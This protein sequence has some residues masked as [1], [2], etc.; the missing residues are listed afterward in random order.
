M[1]EEIKKVIVIDT[2]S[3]S[4][5]IKSLKK[6]IDLL[7]ESLEELEIGSAEYNE[8]L[9]KLSAKQKEYNSVQTKISN[10]TQTT[11]QKFESIAR[12]SSGLAAGYGAVTAAV[13][14]F[15]K[16]SEDLT[17]VMVRLQSAIALVQ[18]IGGL[19]DLLQELPRVGDAFKTL[20]TYINPFDAKLDDIATN[21]NKLDTDK[22]SATADE[23]NNINIASNGG[24]QGSGGSQGGKG[25]VNFSSPEYAANTNKSVSAVAA[26]A[27]TQNGLNSQLNYQKAIVGSL[28]AANT[29]YSSEITSIQAG[30][31]RQRAL[32]A[33]LTSQYKAGT[34]T[35][36]DYMMATL[37]SNRAIKV[38]EGVI[39][40]FSTAIQTNNTK[41]AQAKTAITGLNTAIANSGKAVSKAGQALKSAGMIALWTAIATIVGIV[42]NKVIDYVS[43]LNDAK[44]KEEEFQKSLRETTSQIAAGPIV[45]FQRL[46]TEYLKL[47]DSV[48][49]KEQFLKDY[50]EQLNETGLKL[51]TVNDLDNAFVNRTNDYINAIM[52]R[53]KAQAL[54]TKAIEI[55]EEYLT[56]RAAL[57]EQLTSTELTTKQAFKTTLFI[58]PWNLPSKQQTSAAQNSV[59]QSWAE[60]RAAVQAQIDAL[61]QKIQAKMMKMFSDIAGFEAEYY[62]YFT[63]SV[64]ETVGTTLEEKLNELD[65]WLKARAESKLTEEQR[66]ENE[67]NRLKELAK[68][69]NEALLEIEAWYQE[70][71]TKI[72][73]AARLKREADDK[74][75]SDER[76]NA[77]QAE[78]KRVRDLAVSS[79]LNPQDK[80]YETQYQQ[81]FAKTFGLSGQF[82][83]QSKDDLQRQY[84]DQVAYNNELFNLT[85]SRIEQEN[86]LLNQALQDASLTA[87]RKLEIERTL[88]ENQMALSDAA[89]EKEKKNISAYKNLQDAKNRALQSTLSVASNIAGSMAQIWGEESKTG[90]AFATAQALIDTYSSANAAYSAMAGIPI[91]GPGLG[92]AAAA[93]AIIAGIANVKAIWAVNESGTS[94]SPAVA[95]PPAITA[96]P[97]EYTRNLLGDKEIEELNQ[98][99]KCYVLESDITSTQNKVAVTESNAS[100]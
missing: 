10:S 45:Q 20:M 18:G 73:E 79:N 100:F 66:L 80:L 74:K 70:E 62:A 32:Q 8:T 85:K 63:E 59:E 87:D 94:S 67:Y 86:A 35:Q 38:G 41:I 12:I 53:A 3:S 60:N 26:M 93:A 2:K 29:K 72:R 23:L 92:I 31:D 15:G 37:K 16:E 98:P 47:G 84:D 91:V 11:I 76:W 61:D 55:Y 51:K 77:L 78:L 39:Q 68:D 81:G 27:S 82:T 48:K 19:K 99:V 25:S 43:A 42:I 24:P 57:E 97:V 34:I 9:S 65:Q 4:Q 64:N 50:A 96:P 1:A 21:L 30:I 44:K 52:A 28:T 13:S 7:T 6:D 95:A 90:K 36:Q 71:L 33:E 14:L 75:A 49:A 46:R 22:L 69:N 83:Y 88:R 89:L 40:K 58:G 56:E 5:T 17:R 54:E